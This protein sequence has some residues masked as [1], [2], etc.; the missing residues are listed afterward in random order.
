MQ[1]HIRAMRALADAYERKA[2]SHSFDKAAPILLAMAEA[3][4]DAAAVLQRAVDKEAAA[5]SAGHACTIPHAQLPGR[6]CPACGA[7]RG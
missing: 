7:P 4:R 5:I 1:D 3:Q 2:R 6:F